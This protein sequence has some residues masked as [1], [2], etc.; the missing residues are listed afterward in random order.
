MVTEI[1]DFQIDD[2]D[3]FAS[4]YRSARH[5]LIQ[6]GATSVRMCRGIESP[7]R[8]VLLVEWDSMAAHE[9]FRAGDTFARWRAAVG[10][11]FAADPSVEHVRSVE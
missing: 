6:A 5:L 8:F 11:F 2:A 10:P 9:A 3:G 4:A 1:A 7:R